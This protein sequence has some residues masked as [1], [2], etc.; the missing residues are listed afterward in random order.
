[1]QEDFVKERPVSNSWVWRAAYFAILVAVAPSGAFAAFASCSS[2]CPSQQAC[3]FQGIANTAL[4]SATLS[5]NSSCNLVVDNIGPTG[6][7]GVSQSSLPPN[8]NEVVSEILCPNFAT[9]KQGDM[10]IM[11]VRANVPGGV[12]YTLSIKNIGNSMMEMRPDFSPVGATRY[13][14]TV[15]NGASVAGVFSDL[16]SATFQMAQDDTEEVN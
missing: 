3:T 1:M 13:T 7:D 16:P 5:I 2:S 11:T 14:V 6:Q 10:A 9:S 15:M 12:F 4:G 8:T